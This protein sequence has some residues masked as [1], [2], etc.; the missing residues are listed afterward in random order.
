MISSPSSAR[1]LHAATAPQTQVADIWN[2]ATGEHVASLDGFRGVV[3]DI[4]FSV[5]GGQLAT[6]S[7][8]GSVTLWDPRTGSSV[9]DLRAHD[10]LVSDVSFGP[11]GSV[12]AS[13]SADGTVRIWAVELDHLID[14][15]EGK[16]TRTFTETECEEFLSTPTCPAP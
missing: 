15:A 10:A 16:L 13:T 14:I 1:P 11:D 9:L 3:L 12:L 6:A 5:D 2:L 7:A 4:D 8:D